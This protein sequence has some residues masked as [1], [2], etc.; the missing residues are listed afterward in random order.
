MIIVNNLTPVA[1]QST[2]LKSKASKRIKSIISAGISNIEKKTKGRGLIIPESTLEI[3]Q[4]HVN[5]H[6]ASTIELLIRIQE[7]VATRQYETIRPC[8]LEPTAG[9]KIKQEVRSVDSMAVVANGEYG[10]EIPEIMASLLIGARIAG[11]SSRIVLLKPDING[12]ISPISLYAAYLADATHVFRT[13]G[14]EGL[15]ALSRGWLCDVPEKVFLPEGNQMEMAVYKDLLKNPWKE[16]IDLLVFTDS[17]AG[18]EPIINILAS[19]IQ[20]NPYGRV[21]LV[22]TSKRV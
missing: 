20:D 12:G 14:A 13:G 3:S 5:S 18:V 11:V 21:A 8:T 17:K 9:I 19:W 15:V 1:G 6:V 10:T 2:A 22:T 7:K 16:L 4:H